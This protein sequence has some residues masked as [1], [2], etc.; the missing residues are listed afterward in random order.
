MAEAA[1]SSAAVA[2][3]STAEEVTEAQLAEA[4]RKF[5]AGVQSLK[6]NNL[7]EAVQH[8]GE[9][10]QTRV[11][12]YGDMD[13]R[14]ADAY[15]RYG[16]AL[17]YK[18]Q[19]EADVFGASV[20][21][22]VREKDAAAGTEEQ[23]GDDEEAEE[24]GV[25]DSEKENVD[26]KGKGPARVEVESA[27]DA[28]EE[29]DAEGS[30][31]QLAWE[32]LE[33]AKLIY[34]AQGEEYRKQLADVHMLL[35]D[36]ATEQE[37]FDTALADYE[38]ALTLMAASLPTDDRR[39]GEAHYKKA[40]ALQFLDEPERALQSA[41]AA[42]K[43]G[44]A[45]EIADL[46]DVLEDLLEKVEELN[47]VIKQKRALSKDI[48]AAFSQ[49]VGL[50]A[51][52]QNLGVVGRGSKRINLAALPP[53]TGAAAPAAAP[54]AP[55]Q[56]APAPCVAQDIMPANRGFNTFNTLEAS[57]V[58]SER[59]QTVQRELHDMSLPGDVGW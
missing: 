1:G 53:D 47:D 27:D 23:E 6:D 22:A 10:L 8:F 58:L 40:L 46:E 32:M 21:Q 19:D 43:S 11:A 42:I 16:S 48:K 15:H 59:W 12:K 30:D 33:V 37:G 29:A 25:P 2:S 44:A 38:V 49:V 50:N 51:P 56:A 45:Q 4:D 13:L 18:A 36:I 9:V 14:C 3:S 34:T 17:F 55:G 5:E 41:K 54:A 39:L 57:R 28:P 52:V 7:D 24:E 35:A 20:Q 26:E 31:M